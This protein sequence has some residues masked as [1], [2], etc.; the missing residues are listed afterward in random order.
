MPDS[1]ESGTADEDA[2][3][4][5]GPERL[6]AFEESALGGLAAVALAELREERAEVEALLSQ[7]R[8][9]AET[10]EDSKFETLRAVMA[11]P[12]FASEK[13]I[14]FTEHRDTAGFL[15]RRLEGLG[16]TGRVA[17]IHGG[18][19]YREREAQVALFR[20]PAEDGGAG[21]LV[22][23][24][25]A[26]EGINLQFCWL[27]A[28]YDVPWNPA[29]LEQRMGRIHRYGQAR[30]PVVVVNLIAGETR[31]GRVLK[32]LLDKLE[33]IRKQ[34][35][36]DKVFDV[37]GRLFENVPLKDYLEMAATESGARDAVEALGRRLTA[38]RAAAV[39]RR[40][41]ALYGSGEV[42]DR[43]PEIAAAMERERYRRLLPG[44]VRRFVR[45][46]GS[47]DR[48]AAGGRRGRRLRPRARTPRRRRRRARRDG[49]LPRG[50]AGAL[51]GP[52]PGRR[53]GR[54]L[55]APRRAGVRA[56]PRG[57]A[58]AAGRRRAAGRGFRRSPRRGALSLSSGPGVGRAP[59]RGSG[60]RRSRPAR[61]AC[62]RRAAAPFHPAR[63]SICFSCAG[64]PAPRPA[65]CRWP[66]WRA[67]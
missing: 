34:L 51:D 41:R 65:A 22:A 58:G 17:L 11:D 21:C 36:S 66:V 25:A 55:D 14:V 33:A 32:V 3:D 50:G 26:G 2:D 35:R 39:D 10:G 9:L 15:V 8:R 37:V 67:G 45:V 1:F 53:A 29:R 61:S 38:E 12:A 6:E 23:T 42:R 20:R 47:P 62:G 43:L 7:A 56:L 40:Q 28:N 57:P 13:L 24:D 48:P 52:P 63:R 59:R 31:E 27:M 64:R 5:G 60:R 49:H 44:Y 54:R 16:F 46:R 4:D 19:D 30:D 18:L